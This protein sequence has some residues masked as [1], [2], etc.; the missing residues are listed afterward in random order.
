MSTR[1]LLMA[2]LVFLG[3]CEAA[4]LEMPGVDADVLKAIGAGSGD[5]GLGSL[6][7]DGDGMS[8]ADEEA[9]GTDPSSADTD[10][11]GW[12]DGEEFERNTDPLDGAD[13]PYTGGWP[14]GECRD[15][16]SADTSLAPGNVA[17][18]FEL[19][20]M[21]GD[22]VRLHDFCH[23]AVLVVTGAGWCGP[24]QEYRATM[25]QHFDTY[26]ARGLMVVD[27]MGENASGQSPSQDDLVAWADGHPYAV[28]G[29]PNWS[30]SN[31]GYVSGGIPAMSLLAPG[32]QV[33]YADGRPPSASDIEAI[34]PANFVL[35]EWVELP[36]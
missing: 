30:V 8:D 4:E 15:S 12:L 34:L 32:A 28:L 10:L 5:G 1:I 16:L 17:P 14:I 21:Y 19:T 26:F 20:D 7:S 11:D 31:T 33:V 36:E 25:A 27:L 18:N 13:K 22:T 9:A 35:P 3:G 23:M 24:C 29:D 2:S 6:D